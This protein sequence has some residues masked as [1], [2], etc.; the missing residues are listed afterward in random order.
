MSED[1]V[2][3][4]PTELDKIRRQAIDM[5]KTELE[6]A[7][8]GNVTC[9]ILI[10]KDRDGHWGHQQTGVE[11]FC[12]AIGELEVLKSHWIAKYNSYS[13]YNGEGS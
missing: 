1:V 9:L 6:E 5:L 2:P 13:A 12:D 7:I 3:L 10:S 8:N 11:G 4:F